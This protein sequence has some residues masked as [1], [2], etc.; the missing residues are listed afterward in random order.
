[1]EKQKKSF[2]TIALVVLLLVVTV[3][4]L[5]LAT[6]AWAKYTTTRD[7]GVGTS[8]VVAKWN[9][10]GSSSDLGFTKEFTH[11]IKD[12]LA[13][14][15]SGTIPVELTVAGTEVSV[16]YKVTLLSAAGKPTNLHFYT[17]STKSQEITPGTT[18]TEYANG[19]AYENTIEV[20]RTGSALTAAQ[21]VNEAIYWEWPYETTDG[22]AADTTDGGNAGTMTVQ[23]KIEAEQVRPGPNS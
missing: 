2:G 14:G 17:D 20:T 1:M 5:V 21:N 8:A 16:H 4:S 13:P 3:V 6:Y 19:L 7:N 9:V 11:V 18:G 22:D 12:K 10:D 15:T 23:I